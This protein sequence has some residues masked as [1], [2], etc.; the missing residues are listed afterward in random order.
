MRPIERGGH[1]FDENGKPILFKKY[2][3]ASPYLK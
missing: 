3:E 2:K 1:P